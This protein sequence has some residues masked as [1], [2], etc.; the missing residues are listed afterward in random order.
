MAAIPKLFLLTRHM[1]RATIAA[2]WNNKYTIC[3]QA[4]GA[5]AKDHPWTRR[6]DEALES[7][8]PTRISA[9]DSYWRQVWARKAWLSSQ[10]Y[11]SQRADTSI[12]WINSSFLVMNLLVLVQ[13]F[14]GLKK[15]AIK[16]AVW[17]KDKTMLRKIM[18][19]QAHQFISNRKFCLAVSKWTL[20][21]WVS[22]K[23]AY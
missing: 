7:T 11:S 2:S 16:M 6:R 15:T 3:R 8:A 12:A 23:S 10:Q 14:I 5:P 1:V 19:K 21:F 18:F 13:V 20:N 17:A 9:T 4:T 22:S